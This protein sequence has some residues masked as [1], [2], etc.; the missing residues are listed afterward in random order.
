MKS[1]FYSLYLYKIFGFNLNY[2]TAFFQHQTNLL[3]FNRFNFFYNLL[4]VW[5]I[6]LFLNMFSIVLPN[7]ALFINLENFLQKTFF[8]FFIILG[9][10]QTSWLNLITLLAFLS[11]KTWFK[12]FLCLINKHPLMTKKNICANKY[13][14]LPSSLHISSSH[15]LILDIFSKIWSFVFWNIPND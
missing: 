12:A 4:N 10:N 14:F 6:L 3:I 8:F 7:T 13:L 15:L 2:R 9:P 1:F 5:L 11:P